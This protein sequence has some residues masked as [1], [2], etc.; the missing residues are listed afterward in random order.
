M[1]KD[2]KWT[3]GLLRSS[4]EIE[5]RL[6]EELAKVDCLIGNLSYVGQEYM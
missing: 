4:I 5:T 6:E 2:I 1:Y 3:V